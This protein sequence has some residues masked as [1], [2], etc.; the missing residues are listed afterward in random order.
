MP[1]RLQ[2]TVAPSTSRIPVP[3]PGVPAL[4]AVD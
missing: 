2:P 4:M 1:A 3:Y